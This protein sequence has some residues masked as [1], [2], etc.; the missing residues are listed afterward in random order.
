[1]TA[2]I[3]NTVALD[4]GAI[5]RL[6]LSDDE[7]ILGVVYTSGEQ[8]YDWRIVGADRDTIVQNMQDGRSAGS[9]LHQLI[10]QGT[11]V[12]IDN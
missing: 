9:Y 12:R 6:V 3:D 7:T 2:T 4:S 10:N 5:S 11:L 8:Q 1:M